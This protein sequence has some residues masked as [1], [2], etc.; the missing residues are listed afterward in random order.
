MAALSGS[1]HGGHYLVAKAVLQCAAA[2]PD[3]QPIRQM[4]PGFGHPL[5]PD[6]DVRAAFLLGKL[7]ALAPARYAPY[8]ALARRAAGIPGAQPNS[9]FA[10]AALELM[11]DLPHGAALALL[12]MARTAGWI[13]HALEQRDDGRMIRPRARY[14][15]EF[16]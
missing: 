5:Y 3:T 14:V 12:A 1:E 2:A 10:L 4:T 13:A 8:G 16:G 15:G 11:L 7:Q 6:G 9:D